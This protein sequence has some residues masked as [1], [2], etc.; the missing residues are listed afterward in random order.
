M[1]RMASAYT[2]QGRPKPY[3]AYSSSCSTA[4]VNA[5]SAAGTM[6]TMIA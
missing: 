6:V 3:F 1:A 5:A 2:H 4:P